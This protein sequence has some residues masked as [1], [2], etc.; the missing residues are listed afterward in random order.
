L[1]DLALGGAG[2]A[3][4]QRS[5]GA[6]RHRDQVVDAERLSTTVAVKLVAAGAEHFAAFGISARADFEDWVARAIFVVLDRKALEKRV[7][8]WAGGGGELLS[9]EIMLSMI[10]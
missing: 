8:G 4:T 5:I 1:L 7:A 3:A 2:R 9:H 6:I 10:A